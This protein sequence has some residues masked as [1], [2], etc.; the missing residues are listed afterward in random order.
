[1]LSSFTLKD[2]LAQEGEGVGYS[3]AEGFGQ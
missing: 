3:M 2:V 1:L